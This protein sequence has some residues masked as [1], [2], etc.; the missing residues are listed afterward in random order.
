MSISPNMVAF[1]NCAIFDGRSE[2]LTDSGY[3]VIEDSRIREV[4]TG[5]HRLPE[6]AIRVDCN[7]GVLMPG[8]IDCHFHACAPTFD[9]YGLDRMPA[10]LL[11][12]HAGKALREALLRGFTSV[13]DAGGADIGLALAI[14]RG[15]L[16]GPRLFFS[17]R[18]ISQT[19]GHGDLRPADRIE[20]CSCAYIG[21][22]TLVA[23]GVDE[24]RKAVR[25]EL[26]RGATQIK[27]HVSGGVT[28]P[29]DPMWMP[30]F[31]EEEIRAAVAEARTRRTYVMA[32]C[33]TDDRARVCADLGVRTIEHGTDIRAD[34]ALH[35]AASGTFVV[36]TLS[37][38]YV[39]RDHGKQLGL[40]A[41]SIEK[42]EGAHE[43]TLATIENLQRAGVKLGLGTDL[44]GD[45]QGL[46]SG[47]FG[48]RAE[49][50]SPIEV[51]RSA[52]SVN[53]DIL[54]RSGELGCIAPGAL[55]D[56]IVVDG[57]PLQ[58]IALLG[59]ADRNIPLIMRNGKLVKNRLSAR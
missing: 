50:V 7:G 28:S 45:F 18:G 19:G 24:V 21:I 59:D 20:P 1:E 34:T 22:M 57:N 55:A 36:P 4:G 2:D 25:E 42:I 39:L 47:E 6:N 27:I 11:S 40:P 29:T 16:E 41:A 17:G 30:Q 43:R 14:E 53:A 26:R 33:H 56:L 32:H 5:G 46:Q 13:R 54:Q 51:L 58:D 8:L 9:L 12:Q 44:L 48:L 52:T 10:S 35:I 49:L 15:L 3:V 31:S 37:V 38:V 23:D